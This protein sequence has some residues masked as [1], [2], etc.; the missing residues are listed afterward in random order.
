M[1]KDFSDILC[2][3]N[4]MGYCKYQDKCSF[5]HP[6]DICV[7]VKCKEQKCIKRHPKKCRFFFLR[8]FCKFK[9]DCKFSHK[10][11]GSVEIKAVQTEIEK[12][13]KENADLRQRNNTLEAELND[14]KEKIDVLQEEVKDLNVK[15]SKVEAEYL[16]TKDVNETLL[17]DVENLNERLQLLIPGRVEEIIDE[18]REN[19][20]ILRV[21]LQRYGENFEHEEIVEEE[22]ENCE[23][24]INFVGNSSQDVLSSF[25]C[26]EC[27]FNSSSQRGLSVH[28]GVKH[29]KSS[30][31]S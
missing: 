17:S 20:A 15:L 14:K 25:K 18:L 10:A 3:F 2:K 5:K 9:N 22:N 8:G 7:E 27:N 28:I 12:V 1:E 19:N 16:E 21:T 4:N 23:D 26:E 13:K 31:Y 29:K 30:I 24:L 6:T 11:F